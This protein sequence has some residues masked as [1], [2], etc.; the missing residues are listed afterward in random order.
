MEPLDYPSMPSLNSSPL[1]ANY[2]KSSTS[3][4]P[5]LQGHLSA[6]HI[7][8]VT[9]NSTKHQ[10][11]F[12]KSAPTSIFLLFGISLLLVRQSVRIQ[13]SDKTTYATLCRNEL[14]S[15]I[16]ILQMGVYKELQNPSCHLTLEAP[17]ATFTWTSDRKHFRFYE[18]LYQSQT[19]M[20]DPSKETLYI[21]NAP[22]ASYHYPDHTLEA[23]SATLFSTYRPNLSKSSSIWRAH[24]TMVQLDLQNPTPTFQADHIQLETIR[25]P[26]V[27]ENLP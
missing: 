16:P 20:Y 21:L 7:H 2:G 23:D 8:N 3:F 17:L 27:T 11:M 5:T 24:L 4:P 15:K 1:S 22:Q 25:I 18:I 10:K 9:E 12:F 26:N 19:Q 14:P 13:L 6:A